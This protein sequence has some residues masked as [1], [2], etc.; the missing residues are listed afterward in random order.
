MSAE[1]A[2]VT[3]A[4]E[5]AM[6]LAELLEFLGEWIKADPAGVGEVFNRFTDGLYD[7]EELGGDLARFAFLLGGDGERFV[8]GA[9]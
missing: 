6:E 2:P 3:L 4:A 1:V 9:E 8:S 7:V 5:D